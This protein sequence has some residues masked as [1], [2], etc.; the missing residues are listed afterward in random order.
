MFSFVTTIA[1]SVRLTL[2]DSR[3]R[4]VRTVLDE[5]SLPTGYHDIPIDARGEGGKLLPSGIYFYRLETLEGT[6]TGRLAIIR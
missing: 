1:G 5:P 2:F 4:R 3:G 6:R